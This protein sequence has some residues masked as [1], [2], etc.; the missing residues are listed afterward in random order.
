MRKLLVLVL[1]LVLIATCSAQGRGGFHGGSRG[2]FGGHGFSGRG[3]VGGGGFSG[4]SF[5]GGGF[6][7]QAFG[8]GHAG[9]FYSGYRGYGYGGRWF[10]GYRPYYSYPYR[11]YYGFGFGLGFSYDPR[12]YWPGDYW[13]YYDRCDYAYS[14]GCA[15]YP[16]VLYRHVPVPRTRVAAYAGLDDPPAGDSDFLADGRW[17]H[18]G[19]RPEGVGRTRSEE[20]DVASHPANPLPRGAGLI[21]DG[22]WRHFGEMQEATS[23]E[24]AE[25]SHPGQR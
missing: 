18:F 6:T 13:D 12:W 7:G 22:K 14:Y 1:W 10:G 5:G 20:A 17:R 8:R 4:R 15:A 19:E 2:G 21:A 23:V 16:Y 9:S 3:S 11:S 25:N 24:V